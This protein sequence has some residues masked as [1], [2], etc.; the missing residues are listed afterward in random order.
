MTGTY[1]VVDVAFNKNVYTVFRRHLPSSLPFWRGGVEFDGYVDF[2]QLWG[3]G[4]ETASDAFL[5]FYL[6]DFLIVAFLRNAL[7]AVKSPI[8]DVLEFMVPILETKLGI[9]KE[10]AARRK[11]YQLD[12]VVE[13]VYFRIDVSFQF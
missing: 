9:S 11:Y 7:S 8:L 2:L 6:C 13:H 3:I 12:E 4:E 10:T 1:T 5:A